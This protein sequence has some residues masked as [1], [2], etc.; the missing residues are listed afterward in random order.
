VRRGREDVVDEHGEQPPTP[1]RIWVQRDQIDQKTCKERK[2]GDAVS[3]WF[4]TQVTGF[5][6]Q[7]TGFVTQVD[8]FVTQVI[9]F[10]CDVGER[11]WS[12]ST[13]SSLRIYRYVYIYTHTHT[14]THTYIYIYIYRV[15]GQTWARGRG[16]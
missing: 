16:R 8:G 6:T 5:V 10:G 11:T 9:G 13:G 4:V 1:P 12:M 15:E 2:T 14:H 7:V 3:N